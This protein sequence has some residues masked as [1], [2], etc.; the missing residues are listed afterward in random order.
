MGSR[1]LKTSPHLTSRFTSVDHH[2]QAGWKIACFPWLSPAISHDCGSHWQA[3]SMSW[4][5]SWHTP[6]RF[7]LASLDHEY[8]LEPPCS[9]YPSAHLHLSEHDH[10][11]A[12]GGISEDLSMHVCQASRVSQTR[13]SHPIWHHKSSESWIYRFFEGELHLLLLEPSIQRH[14]AWHFE[15]MC[16]TSDHEWLAL[17]HGMWE[18]LEVLWTDPRQIELSWL[19]WAHIHHHS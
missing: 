12:N 18:V 16:C 7:S 10:T 17:S 15:H 4:C 1:K 3:C 8:L 5:R 19:N 13:R 2:E 11:T 9:K 6:S 14:A